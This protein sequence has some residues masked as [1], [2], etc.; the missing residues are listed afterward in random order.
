MSPFLDDDDDD[1]RDEHK[2]RKPR[3]RVSFSVQ[4]VS[5]GYILEVDAQTFVFTDLS[6]VEDFISKWFNGL[7]WKSNVD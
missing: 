4:K 1:E 6:S 5:N 3:N 7:E 2:K